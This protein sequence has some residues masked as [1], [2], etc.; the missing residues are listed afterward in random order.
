MSTVIPFSQPPG[1]SDYVWRCPCGCYSFLIRQD[2]KAECN[3]CG[4]VACDEF[5]EWRT[6]LPK[7]PESAPPIDQDDMCVTVVSSD[8]L[9]LKRVLAKADAE[10]TCFV[11]IVQNGGQVTTWGHTIEHDAGVK[12]LDER[13]S[14]IRRMMTKADSK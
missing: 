5:G 14:D 9:A 7:T 2:M 4:E 13:L 8:E 12:W 6:Q 10:E 1:P 11:S 3:S